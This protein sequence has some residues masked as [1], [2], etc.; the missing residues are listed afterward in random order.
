MLGQIGLFVSTP[1]E[2]KQSQLQTIRNN[3]VSFKITEVLKNF[4]KLFLLWPNTFNSTMQWEC[5]KWKF[6]MEYCTQLYYM[7]FH[8]LFPLGWWST[9]EL[10]S[11]NCKKYNIKDWWRFSAFSLNIFC[12]IWQF[13]MI[14]SRKMQKALQDY[15]SV[16]KSSNRALV[17][18]DC[19]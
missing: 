5:H 10:V 15:Y 14:W 17:I 9:L 19:V 4:V 7:K 12:L 2:L 13:W 1:N 8:N 18:D 11:V 6:C 3:K 16:Q